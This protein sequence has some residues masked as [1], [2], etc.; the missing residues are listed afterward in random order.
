[1]EKMEEQDVE[2]V[3]SSAKTEIVKQKMEAARNSQKES[4]AP[5]TK[6]TSWQRLLFLFGFSSL[7]RPQSY[8]RPRFILYDPIPRA[9]DRVTGVKVGIG[10]MYDEVQIRMDPTMAV[11]FGRF[12]Q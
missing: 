7:Q 12:V 3:K 1:M 10:M 11:G 4:T 9:S 6:A 5:W 2:I 8:T